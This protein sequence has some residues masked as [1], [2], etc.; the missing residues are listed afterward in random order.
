MNLN[1]G[2]IIIGSLYWD[3]H[4]DKSKNDFIRQLW[5]QNNLEIDDLYVPLPICYGRKSNRREIFTM[6]YSSSKEQHLGQGIV[7]KFKLP[8]NSFEDVEY[9]AIQ[10]AKAEGIYTERNTNISSNWG[11]VG[12]LI[13]PIF[14]LRDREAFENIEKN[15]KLLYSKFKNTFKSQTY[16]FDSD[17][18]PVIDNDGIIKIKWHTT[19][20]NYDFLLSTVN[21]PI[22][23][24]ESTTCEIANAMNKKSEF[25]YFEKNRKS[26]IFTFLDSEIEKK[27]NKNK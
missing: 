20:D 27:L 8:I 4:F 7:K 5:R 21:V 25:E 19:L 23:V 26:N 1:A 17:E 2:V 14:H 24:S 18:N 11:S 13:N 6:I 9:Q 16:K 22:P 12:L 10:L 3:D 15:W